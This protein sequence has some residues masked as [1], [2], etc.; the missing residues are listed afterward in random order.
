[1]E[2]KTNTLFADFVICSLKM[3]RN[4]G[5][6]RQRVQAVLRTTYVGLVILNILQAIKH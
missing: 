6:E 1:M 5:A 2:L 4:R 3:A